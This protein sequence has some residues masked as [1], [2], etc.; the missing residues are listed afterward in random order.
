[1]QSCVI[2]LMNTQLISMIRS[3]PRGIIRRNLK[4]IV[5]KQYRIDYQILV[6]GVMVK[7]VTWYF[8]ENK[9]VQ[10]TNIVLVLKN[11]GICANE[12]S[13]KAFR[14]EKLIISFRKL[15][16]QKRIEKKF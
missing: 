7:L 8:T 1:M 15:S 5:V 2:R 3:Y 10:V 9:Q 14:T 13:E 11:A 6:F 4:Q 16:K 12:L